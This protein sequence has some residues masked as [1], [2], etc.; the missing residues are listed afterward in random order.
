[1]LCCRYLHEDAHI[2]HRDLKPSNVLL[3]DKGVVKLC[4]FGIATGMGSNSNNP[5]ER[6]SNKNR[7]PGGTEPAVF[8]SGGT[9]EYVLCLLRYQQSVN[10]A[11]L[12]RTEVKE[13]R[14]NQ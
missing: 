2:V 4:D 5:F 11:V 1:V 13:E 3:T 8:T 10:S 12:S 9:I 14:K 7:T 6:T